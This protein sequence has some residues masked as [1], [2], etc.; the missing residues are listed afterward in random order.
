MFLIELVHFFPI[1]VDAD[2]HHLEF[3]VFELLVQRLHFGHFLDTGLAPGTPDIQKHNLAAVI[4]ELNHTALLI[5]DRKIR[6]LLPN[7]DDTG[8]TFSSDFP[9]D[10]EWRNGTDDQKED[11]GFYTLAHADNCNISRGQ[12]G[13][14]HIPA[15]PCPV[16][17]RRDSADG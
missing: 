9:I 2:S 12:G 17:G 15:F 13:S 10:E 11:D 16:Q 5:L 6:R 8:L 14:P 7:I 3:P 1:I 4:A